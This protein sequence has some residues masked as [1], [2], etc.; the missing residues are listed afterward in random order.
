MILDHT[1]LGFDSQWYDL[2]RSAAIATIKN[3]I[4]LIVTL[5]TVQIFPMLAAMAVIHVKLFALPYAH[6]D[7]YT[8]TLRLQSWPAHNRD[9]VN[10]AL[11]VVIFYI[12]ELH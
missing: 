5:W 8:F 9:N 12:S 6:H 2:M 7:S 4:V 3:V 10:G 11:L 1:L